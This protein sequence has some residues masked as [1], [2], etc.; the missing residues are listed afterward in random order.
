MITELKYLVVEDHDQELRTLQESLLDLG[1][2]QYL[3]AAKSGKSAREEI[4]A[5]LSD[6]D[7]VFLDLSIPVSES[8]S[9]IDNNV[10]FELLEWIHTSVNRQNDRPLRVIIVSGQ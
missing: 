3:G 1:M 2:S 8:S 7:L 9:R 6:L 5:H 10:G 4:E